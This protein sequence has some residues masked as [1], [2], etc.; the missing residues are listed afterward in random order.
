MAYVLW[1]LHIQ[2]QSHDY[3]YPKYAWIF[4]DWYRD[5]WWTADVSGTQL[6]FGAC[7]DSELTGFLDG[8][9][10][11]KLPD[12]SNETT[13]IGAVSTINVEVFSKLKLSEPYSS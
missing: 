11:I 5:G 9:I 1:I 4:Y 10:T 12:V 8:A 3:T 2:A 13:D 7:T 6:E